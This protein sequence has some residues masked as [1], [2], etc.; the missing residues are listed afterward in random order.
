ME[1]L[2]SVFGRSRGAGHGVGRHV[3][4]GGGAFQWCGAATRG[5]VHAEQYERGHPQIVT[6]RFKHQRLVERGRP[7]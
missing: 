3:S 5:E 2:R 6:T 1:S 7:S 4:G